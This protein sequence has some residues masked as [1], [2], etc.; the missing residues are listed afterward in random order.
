[1]NKY[2]IQKNKMY[3]SFLALICA[4]LACNIPNVERSVIKNS[5]DEIVDSIVDEAFNED[6]IAVDR[7]EY[8]RA[9][10]I[11][12][13][14][15]ES[16]K[17]PEGAI[18]ETC[19]EYGSEG[20]YDGLYDA[21]MIDGPEPEKNEQVENNEINSIPAGTYIYEVF[22]DDQPP[23]GGDDWE[24]ELESEFTIRV[25]NDGTVKGNKIYKL[26]VDNVNTEGCATRSEEGFTTNV[27]G[28]LE[29]N[30]GTVKLENRHWDF[31]EWHGDKCGDGKEYYKD[32]EDECDAIITVSG[33][34]MEISCQGQIIYTLIKE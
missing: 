30:Q 4:S 15:P 25:A 2:S 3:V 16:P 34:Q 5:E 21:N 31:W 12:N 24:Y 28:F 11:L 13:R 10:A 8:E 33:N 26:W 7:S 23:P 9:V 18:Y 1:M 19:Y 6:C 17:Y 20:L 14:E 27:S 22:V 29:G 32:E